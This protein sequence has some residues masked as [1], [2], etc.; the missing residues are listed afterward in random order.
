[1][2]RSESRRRCFAVLV[3]TAAGSTFLVERI[4]VEKG[5]HGDLF[6]HGL[7][8]R[9]YCVSHEAAKRPAEQVVGPNGLNP[10][11]DAQIVRRH[12]F[13]GVGQYLSLNEIACL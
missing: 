5:E 8:L 4:A 7:K 9:G 12:A 13:N 6:A 10:S 3:L 1:M 2:D 11:N